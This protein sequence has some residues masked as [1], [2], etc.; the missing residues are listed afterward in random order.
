MARAHVDGEA[1][2]DTLN[3]DTV[4]WSICEVIARHTPFPLQEI[5]QAYWQLGSVDDTLFATYQSGLLGISLPE[6]CNMVQKNRRAE[7]EMRNR[8]TPDFVRH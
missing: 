5:V 8:E 1:L 7:Q 6:S 2:M 3:P 4:E